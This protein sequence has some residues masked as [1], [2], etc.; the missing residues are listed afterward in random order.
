MLEPPDHGSVK[1]EEMDVWQED[2][3]RPMS[4]SPTIDDQYGERK[5][6]KKRGPMAPPQDRQVDKHSM[7]SEDSMSPPATPDRLKPTIP[8]RRPRLERADEAMEALEE[9]ELTKKLEERRR[10]EEFKK[11]EEIKKAEESRRVEEERKEEET[12]RKEE[13]R[14]IELKKKKE[15]LMPRMKRDSVHGS[16]ELMLVLLPHSRATTEER[17]RCTIKT[18][19]GL[20]N[21][22][23]RY[24]KSGPKHSNIVYI[25]FLKQP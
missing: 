8:R 5:T 14:L 2:K 22:K 18:N 24:P 9:K 20:C 16:S 25:V 6:K 17:G 1:A 10:V 11:F 4:T 21:F 15:P 19:F 13:K 7:M 12:K 23:V 3:K